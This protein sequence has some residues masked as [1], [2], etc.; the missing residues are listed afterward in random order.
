MKRFVSVK[1]PHMRF[2]LPVGNLVDSC[3]KSGAYVCVK[4]AGLEI[5]ELRGQRVRS[6]Q[7][8]NRADGRDLSEAMSEF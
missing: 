4:E 3:W 8:E 1:K 2:G 7:Q 5:G 6:L